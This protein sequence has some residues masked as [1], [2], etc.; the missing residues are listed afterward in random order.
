[1]AGND[2]SAA[3]IQRTINFN[4]TFCYS[5]ELREVWSYVYCTHCACS[6]RMVFFVEQTWR[7]RVEPCEPRVRGSREPGAFPLFNALVQCS[8][9][10]ARTKLQRAFAPFFASGCRRI[11]ILLLPVWI[12]Y[13]LQWETMQQL[14]TSFSSKLDCRGGKGPVTR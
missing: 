8:H 1:M 3:T 11:A 10:V 4:A 7:F 12:L 14:L 5:H 13:N 2:L 9:S 6:R